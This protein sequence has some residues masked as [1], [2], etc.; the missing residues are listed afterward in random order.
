MTAIVGFPSEQ[1]SQPPF[2]HGWFL[3]THIR[4]FQAVIQPTTK[5]IIELGSWY[6][7]STRWFVENSNAKIYAIDLWD[8][9]FILNDNHY[10][11]SPELKSMLRSHPLYSTFLANL[12]EYKDRVIPIKMN[13]LD[14]LQY[15]Y[16][17]GYYLGSL[18][19]IRLFASHH[20]CRYYPRYNLHRC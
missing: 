5:V 19:S 1:P 4:V 2:H 16:D 12:W 7:A 13:T 3:E 14:G 18:V 11:R 10:N 6:G 9:S 15:L 20:F 8:D 17:Q